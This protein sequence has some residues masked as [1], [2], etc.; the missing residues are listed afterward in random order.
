MPTTCWCIHFR[1]ETAHRPGFDDFLYRLGA[2]GLRYRLE[3]I[4]TVLPAAILNEIR[5]SARGAVTGGPVTGTTDPA[6]ARDDDGHDDTDEAGDD[7]L[8]SCDDDNNCGDGM[9]GHGEV[10]GFDEFVLCSV[11]RPG[12]GASREED[13]KSTLR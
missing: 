7:C 6:V 3:K 8:Q 9:G 5:R 1:L 2:C 10:S 13:P 11:F 12:D 4:S